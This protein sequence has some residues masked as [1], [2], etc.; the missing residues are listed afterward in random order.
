LETVEIGGVKRISNTALL[1][2]TK[3]KRTKKFHWKSISR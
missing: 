1:A 3:I 2:F